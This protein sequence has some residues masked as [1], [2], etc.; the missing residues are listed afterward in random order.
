MTVYFG[1]P[2]RN[3]EDPLISIVVPA[4]NEALNLS[5][6]LPQL[7]HVHEVILVD[8]GSVDGTVMAARRAMPNIVTVLDFF[9]HDGQLTKQDVRA[10]TL[11]ALAPTPG[12]RLWDVGAGS[13]SIGI[14]WLLCHPACRAIAI[15]R[16]LTI[17]ADPD[18][19]FRVLLNLVRNAA[20]ALESHPMGGDRSSM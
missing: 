12:A 1:T 13:G 9:E 4:L 15:E 8:G 5:V 11:A 20:Q 18:Q 3:T 14:E 17:D 7:P 10:I 19:L 2:A 6:V 16:G